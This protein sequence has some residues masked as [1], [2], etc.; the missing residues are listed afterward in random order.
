MNRT[1]LFFG[2]AYSVAVIAFKLVILLGGYSLSKFGW[3]YSNITGV[4][5]I[6]PFYMLAIKKVRDKD[7]GGSIAGREAMRIA[8]TVFVVG[9]ILVSIYNYFEFEMA[10]KA[11]AIEYYNSEQFLDYL[12]HLKQVK[13]ED[14][15][16]IIAEQ[17]KASE[18][19]AFK[20]TTGKLFSF[21]LISVSS[22]F[23]TSAVMKRS[24]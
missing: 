17:V 22:A 12:K 9:A 3:Y 4:F 19:S 15:S 7:N 6:I 11:M 21:I 1:G 13:A 18:V 2:L 24:K 20:A 5:L 16:K 23:I 14:Y 8:L 10:G